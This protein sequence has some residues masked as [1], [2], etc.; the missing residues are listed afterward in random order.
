[1][2]YFV[3]EDWS[4]MIVEQRTQSIIVSKSGGEISYQSFEY[5]VIMDE[6]HQEISENLA[7][8]WKDTILRRLNS[9]MLK[10]DKAF[11]EGKPV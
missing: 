9:N 6:G 10:I 11:S 2:R 4:E 3:N 5:P 8:E 7:L 1:M